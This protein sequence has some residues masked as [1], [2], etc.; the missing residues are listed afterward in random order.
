[1]NRTNRTGFF[2]FGKAFRRA[3]AADEKSALIE[4][5]QRETAAGKER[6]SLSEIAEELHGPRYT[7]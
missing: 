5:R 6:R 7:V 2:H 4:R 1:M 3:I